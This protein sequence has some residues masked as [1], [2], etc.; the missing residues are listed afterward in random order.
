MEEKT[1]TRC[2]LTK[3]ISEFYKQGEKYKSECK[4][5][6]IKLT[7]M[8]IDKNYKR[9]KKNQ[10]NFYKSKNGSILMADNNEKMKPFHKEWVKR[11]PEKV[12]EYGVRHRSKSHKI[13]KVEW[14][15]CLEFFQYS[16]AYCGMTQEQSLVIYG[17]RLHKDHF[18]NSGSNGIDNAIPACKSC[19][20]KKHSKDAILWYNE[21]N[22]VFSESRMSKILEWLSNF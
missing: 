4:E 17:Q 12:K 22:D 2:G 15:E 10:S 11:N 16:C 8:W 7:R 1:C 13:T 5:C 3:P 18:I 14:N 9:W 6:S 20:S 21:N 19:N